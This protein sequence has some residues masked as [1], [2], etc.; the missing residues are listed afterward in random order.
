MGGGMAPLH[1]AAESDMVG[2]A[3]L[4]LK[5]GA[6]VTAQDSRG[7]TPLH[8]A[9]QEGG[10]D[11]TRLLLAHGADPHMRD[12]SGHNAAW[13][14]KQFKHAEVF[15]IYTDMQ[16]EPKNISIREQMLHA[17]I[18]P[19][20]VKKDKKRSARDDR[21]SPQPRAKSAPAPSQT[22]QRQNQH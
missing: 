13:W 11:I 3:S 10:R 14:A 1:L 22:R 6:H 9:A 19:G 7:R 2:V 21:K 8:A 12:N 4:L 16:V 18:T 20:S 15:E 5:A 17:G